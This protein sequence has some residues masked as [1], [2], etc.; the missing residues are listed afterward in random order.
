MSDTGHTPIRTIRVD[1]SPVQTAM[2]HHPPEFKAE[3]VVLYRCR[4]GAATTSVADDLGINHETLRNRIRLGDARCTG[5][6]TAVAVSPSG[7]PEDENAAL[8]R[9]I[10][11]LEKE[12]DI[13]CK[14]ARHF[15]GE[16]RW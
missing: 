13:L 5:P 15:A 11:E 10:R 6:H 7:S 3:A 14:A 8:L 2:K 12:R 9:R 1:R 4:P 16:T